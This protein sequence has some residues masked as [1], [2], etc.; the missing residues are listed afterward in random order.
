LLLVIATVITG[1]GIVVGF[2]MFHNAADASQVDAVT[3]ECLSLAAR[4]QMHYMTPAYRGGGGYS[5]KTLTIQKLLPAS[6]NYPVGENEHGVFS[7]TPADREMLIVGRPR[8]SSASNRVV[9]TTVTPST[10]ST[11]IEE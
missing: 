10:M 6:P 11:T 4:A 9:K 5:F 3:Q 2:T 1:V 8:R 7:I